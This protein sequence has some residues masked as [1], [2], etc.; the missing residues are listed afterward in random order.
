MFNK[1]QNILNNTRRTIIYETKTDMV[2]DTYKRWI[3][4]QYVIMSMFLAAQIPSGTSN[5]ANFWWP[6][7]DHVHELLTYKCTYI[8]LLKPTFYDIWFIS[9]CILMAIILTWCLFICQVSSCLPLWEYAK[10]NNLRS[11]E[12][13]HISIVSFQLHRMYTQL[14][15]LSIYVLVKTKKLNRIRDLLFLVCFSYY[16]ILS[17]FLQYIKVSAAFLKKM[18]KSTGTLGLDI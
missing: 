15:I 4:V 13:T 1:W 7:S 3:I 17:V 14:P 18:F 8:F 5:C 9:N 12:V 2:K 16:D 6:Y 11:R 10:V